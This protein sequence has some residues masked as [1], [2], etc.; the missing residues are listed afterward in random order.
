MTCRRSAVFLTF[1]ALAGCGSTAFKPTVFAPAVNLQDPLPGMAIVYLLRIPRDTATVTVHFDARK[2]AVIRPESYT[3]VSVKPGTY[4]VKALASD[5]PSEPASSVLT[6]SAGERRFLYTSMPNQLSA[7][8]SSTFI[9]RVG[10]ITIATPRGAVARVRTWKEC[11]ELD[12]QGLMSSAK[13]VLPE[14]GAI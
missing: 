8:L 4:E 3:A 10:Y 2:M 6:V 11:S 13:V 7:N 5:G 14:P 12:A 9:P 1:F